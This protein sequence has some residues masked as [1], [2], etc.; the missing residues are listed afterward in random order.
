MW[1]SSFNSQHIGEKFE[2]NIFD[3]I[4]LCVQLVAQFPNQR[5]LI[6]GSLSI[7]FKQSLDQINQVYCK[8]FGATNANINIQEQ[9]HSDRRPIEKTVFLNIKA[10]SSSQKEL[11]LIYHA[12]LKTTE[13]T[14]PRG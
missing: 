1:L 14:A 8:A 5:R 9:L 3:R 11:P 6:E 4:L 13:T 10:R 7:K 12:F 2:T